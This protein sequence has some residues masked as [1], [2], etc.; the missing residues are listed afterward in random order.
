MPLE[1]M[2]RVIGILPEE[3]VIFDP[4]TGSGTTA[5]ACKELKRDFIG[6]ELNQAYFEEALRRLDDV[7]GRFEAL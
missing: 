2:K 7:R 3:Y 5:L 1:V 4:F 6:T